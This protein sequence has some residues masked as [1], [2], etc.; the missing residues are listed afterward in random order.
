MEIYRQ[1][2]E[3]IA[4]QILSRQ[5]QPGAKIPGV[6]QLA[7]EM[8][9]AANTARRSYIELRTKGII[10]IA[11]TGHLVA[12]DAK[13]LIISWWTKRLLEVELP[14]FFETMYLLNIGWEEIENGFER[15]KNEFYILKLTS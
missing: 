9:I 1:V 7:K 11:G 2:A 4:A 3:H 13:A 5:L 15:Y 8:G 10:L 14:I 12:A 6:R